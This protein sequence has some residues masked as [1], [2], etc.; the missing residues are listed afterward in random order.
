MSSWKPNDTV[1]KQVGKNRASREHPG[2]GFLILTTFQF[3]Y[4][5]RFEILVHPLAKDTHR[6]RRRVMPHSG[7]TLLKDADHVRVIFFI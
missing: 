4:P 6:F 5:L 3:C 7:R 1:E 2:S